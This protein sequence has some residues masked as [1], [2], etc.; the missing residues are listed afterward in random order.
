MD[1]KI[2]FRNQAKVRAAKMRK[3]SFLSRA[4]ILKGRKDLLAC[5][6]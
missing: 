4:G 1:R 5:Q 6:V 3:T 2:S